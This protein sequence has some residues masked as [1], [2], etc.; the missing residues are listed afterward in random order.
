MSKVWFSPVQWKHEN[1][2]WKGGKC[3][4]PKFPG[5]VYFECSLGLCWVLIP[6]SHI[7]KLV[8]CLRATPTMNFRIPRFAQNRCDLERERE[9]TSWQ[10]TRR[11]NY[12]D[13]SWERCRR[14]CDASS[15]PSCV[16]VTTS[17]VCIQDPEQG[18]RRSRRELDSYAYDTQCWLH[19]FT[20]ERTF[21]DVQTE[22]FCNCNSLDEWC[23]IDI[24]VKIVFCIVNPSIFCVKCSLKCTQ[25]FAG[26]VP[27]ISVSRQHGRSKLNRR[28]YSLNPRGAHQVC[29]ELL[30]VDDEYGSPLG[31]GPRSAWTH[32]Y[33]R[34]SCWRPIEFIEYFSALS[35]TPLRIVSD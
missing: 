13:R 35:A 19:L 9:E 15:N 26:D 34:G 30:V 20:S 3:E 33:T 7:A 8:P 27:F 10:L 14:R 2:L 6:S 1:I 4:N 32:V 29:T 11:A 16:T 23:W 18:V 12:G 22:M 31:Q 17:T 21:N 5:E 24:K 25:F 28:K